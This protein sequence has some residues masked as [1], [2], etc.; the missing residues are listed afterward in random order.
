M[1]K[2]IVEVAREALTRCAS[3][4]QP[5]ELTLVGAVD[6]HGVD[7]TFLRWRHE[8]NGIGV[9]DD[10]AEFDNDPSGELRGDDIPDSSEE[11]HFHV[12]ARDNLGALAAE[13]LSARAQ[14]PAPAWTREAPKEPGWYWM[15]DGSAATP[16]VVQVHG[17]ELERTGYD[18]ADEIRDRYEFWPVRL[19][20]PA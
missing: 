4:P 9:K 12:F 15:R 10:F 7:T 6:E 19:E 14:S 18:F 1:T 16:E 11:A 5:G 13:V 20:P 8:R 2:D 17:R 3:G